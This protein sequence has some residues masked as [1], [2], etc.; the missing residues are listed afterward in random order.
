MHSPMQKALD[1]TEIRE[2]VRRSRLITITTTGY[3][4]E[5]RKYIDDVLDIFLEE[6]GLAHYK[7]KLSYCV[8][9]LAGNAIKGNSK[10]VYF[11][12]KHLD[13]Q[14]ETEYWIGMQNFHH[15][16]VESIAYYL[17]RQKYMGLTIKIQFKLNG[18]NVMIGVRQ[19]VGLTESERR[20]I[21]K[22]ISI[23]GHFTDMNQ[24][25]SH[26]EDNSGDAGI[27]T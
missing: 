10:R 3:F 22:K 9:E 21:R 19:N 25:Y 8:H 6:A 14:N 18:P 5:E 12:E 13:I 15:E 7:Q 24:A 1:R 27:G 20:R 11:T 17:R 16:T 2:A 23:S 26:I 4:S